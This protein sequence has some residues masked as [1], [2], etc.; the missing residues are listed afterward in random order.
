MT[1]VVYS[2]LPYFSRSWRRGLSQDC[3][4]VQ[5]LVE[6]IKAGDTSAI[7]LG[8]KGLASHPKL[9]GFKGI[10]TAAPRSTASRPSNMVIAQELVRHGVGTKALQMVV[11]GTPVPSSRLRRRLGQ[12]GIPFAQHLDSMVFV[13]EPNDEPVLIIDDMFTTGTTL[14]AT[15]ARIRKGGHRG[16][17]AGATIGYYVDDEARA[18]DCP[19]KH[20]VL[21]A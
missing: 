3:D 19:I 15:A 7:K 9:R 8:V 16:P 17:L 10:V 4:A 6:A 12:E 18:R 11:R 1:L 13:G 2:S 5:D 21:R 14:K 20:V